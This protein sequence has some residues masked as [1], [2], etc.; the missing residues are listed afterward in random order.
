MASNTYNLNTWAAK[1]IIGDNTSQNPAGALLNSGSGRADNST[2]GDTWIFLDTIGGTTSPWGFKHAQGANN[3][4]F[5]GGGTK[6]AVIHLGSDAITTAHLIGGADTWYTARTLTIGNTGK[7]VN[8]SANVSWSK[9]EILGASTSAYFLRGDKVWSDTLT[10]PLN[11]S[12]TTA[13]ITWTA[14]TNT[15][16]TTSTPMAISYGRL[17]CYGTLN[18]N[19]NTDNSGTEYVILTAGKGMSSTTTDGLYVGTSTMGF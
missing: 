5:F 18:I 14:S 13:A 17:Q 12:G 4:E 15:T 19:A 11:M 1:R 10:G 16:P 6:R 2:T 7:S 8:G 9:D 3:I